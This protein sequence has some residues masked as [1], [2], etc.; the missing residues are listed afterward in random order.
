VWNSRLIRCQIE[1]AAR[2]TAG[3]YKINQPHICGFSFPLPPLEE[4]RATMERLTPKLDVVER[5]EAELRTSLIALV[6]LRQSILKRAFSG[7]LVPQDPADEP[8]AALL[9]RLRAEDAAP[10]RKTRRKLPA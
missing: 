5:Q 7:S 2:T 10:A 1:A 4:Q 8:A 6:A 9:A 3:I